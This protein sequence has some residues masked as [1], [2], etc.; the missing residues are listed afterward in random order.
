MLKKERGYSSE[1]AVPRLV[2]I[3]VNTGIGRRDEKEREAIIR[4]FQMIVGQKVVPRPARTSIA[5]FKTRIGLIIGLSA[6]LRGKRMYDFLERLIYVAIPRLRDFRG[7]DPKSV[8]AQGNLTVGF[9]EHT[10]FPEMIGEDAKPVF[11]FEVTLVANARTRDEALA[12]YRAIGIPF[13]K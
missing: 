2:K 7:I 10:V 3:V 11:G 8:D 5:A 9:K 6:T 13:Q 1:L 12:L 4:Q